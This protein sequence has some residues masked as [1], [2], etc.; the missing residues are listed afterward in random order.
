VSGSAVHVLHDLLQL[1][2]GIGF[3]WEHGLHLYERRAHHDAR[4][5]GNPRA[6]A[7]ALAALEGWPRGA[8]GGR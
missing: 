3:T 5:A 7:R 1:T 6:A 4:L 2:G 8:D